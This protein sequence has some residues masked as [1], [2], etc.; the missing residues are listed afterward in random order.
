LAT[1][2]KTYRVDYRGEFQRENSHSRAEALIRASGVDVISFH[3]FG[4]EIAAPGE[5]EFYRIT[6]DAF[7]LHP[8]YVLALGAKTTLKIGPALKYVSTDPRP[9]RFLATLGDVYGSGNFGEIGGGVSFLHDTRDR[10]V[11]ATRGVVLEIGGSMYPPIW[12][13]DSTFGEVHGEAA[14]YLS[15]RIPLQPTLALRVGGKKLWGRYPFFESAFI[16]GGSN[17]RLGRVN[18]YAGDAAAYGS[19]ELRLSVTRLTLVLP[20]DFGV[21]GLADVGRVFLEGES[22][23][24][25]HSAAGAGI[26]ISYMNRAY[27]FSLA[28][29]SGEERTGL[30]AQAGFGF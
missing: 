13:V 20:A 22:S 2:P 7:G 23:D 29:A 4:N 21:F 8:S 27:T 18:R 25:W 17:V 16:G 3:G 5:N 1:G 30:Y 24:Q 9:G 11:A 19:A 12:D 28:L 10:Q 14:T 15:A 26:W 6:Q